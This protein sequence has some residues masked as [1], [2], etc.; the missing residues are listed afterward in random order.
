LGIQLLPEDIR[1]T[2]QIEERHHAC[3]TLK[4][5]F[6]AEWDDLI[7]VLRDFTLKKSAVQA[8]GGRKSPIADSIDGLFATRKWI[9]RSFE[10][11]VTAD[12]VSTLAPTHSVDYYKNRIVA[13]ADCTTLKPRRLC[14]GKTPRCN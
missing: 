1:A 6:P 4:L 10:I 7:A 12:G 13:G 9:E 14:Q 8:K 11:N 5:D 3:A 2:Y